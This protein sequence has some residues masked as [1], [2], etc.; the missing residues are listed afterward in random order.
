MNKN[1][2]SNKFKIFKML[3]LIIVSSML[4][5]NKTSFLLSQSSSVEITGLGP[6]IVDGKSVTIN[7]GA[8][9]MKGKARWN[10][11]DGKEDH[12]YFLATHTY[13]QY[14]NYTVTVTA[15]GYDGSS[16]TKSI[17]V[18]LSSYLEP[19]KITLLNPEINDYTVK[20][21]GIVTGAIKPL[22]FD[23]GDREVTESW[24]PGIHQYKKAGTYTIT[25]TAYGKDGT[26]S[27]AAMTVT[28]LN[29]VKANR[30]TIDG[31]VT[32]ALLGS[33]IEGVE[34]RGACHTT[35]TDSKGYYKLENLEA[36][37]HRFHF[38]KYEYCYERPR[39]TVKA[40][41]TIRYSKALKLE[42][43][44][45]LRGRVI[46]PTGEG[47]PG[48]KVIWPGGKVR[49]NIYDEISTTTDI[50]GNY[51][52]KVIP[53]GTRTFMF[54]LEGCEKK[55]QETTIAEGV[56]NV[57]ELTLPLFDFKRQIFGETQTISVGVTNINRNTGEVTMNGGDT[58]QPQI[59][60]TWDWDDGVIYDD[61]IFQNHTY[62]DITRNY[63]V[64]VTAHY[65]DGT[66][67]SVEISVRFVPPPINNIELPPEILVKIPDY[68]GYSEI[69]ANMPE[70]KELTY[71]DD[72]YFE[73][74]PR[75]T[76]EYVLSAAALIQKDFVN[77][78][79]NDN[80]FQVNG[81]FEQYLL[82]D[83]NLDN[84]IGMYSLWFTNPVAFVSKDS[85]LQETIFWSSFFHEMGHN[86]TLNFP[87]NYRYGGKI[88]GC[89]NA[90]FSESLAQIF[91]HATAYEMI[92]EFYRNNK[93]GL[94]E[95]LVD[96]IKQRAIITMN[97]VRKHYDKYI[98]EGKNFCSWNE[99]CGQPYDKDETK[100]TFMTI[101]FKFFE[102]AEKGGQG[103]KVPLKKMMEFLQV[104][105]EE[106]KN[107]Y[108]PTQNSLQ[109]DEF[110]A[111]FMVTALS[112]AFS[113]DLRPEFRDLN[114]PIS[115]EKYDDL[116]DLVS[117]ATSPGNMHDSN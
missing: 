24:F 48:I 68:E 31:Y 49:G 39:I 56:F 42:R 75:S 7:G 47:I 36:G 104:F 66:T 69:K 77:V 110:R 10:W 22:R 71:F 78:N 114:F 43:H 4:G 88:D 38:Y 98:D 52:L 112:Y 58:R 50:G 26:E 72:T 29:V 92:N 21:N 5:L 2:R 12:Q 18:S 87:A 16:D 64:K 33:V 67:D 44:G 20:Q 96:E 51:L 23:W 85:G 60:F 6:V 82:K 76:I 55:I 3:L 101:A 9:N 35:Y 109:G 84:N 115:N 100:D 90:I 53:T 94:T 19:P 15:Y 13:E 103:Y 46:K 74:T 37:N 27:S 117:A 62:S 113:T 79:D 63:T 73:I 41:K 65:P 45:H 97:V 70:N 91:Q 59:P 93:Y 17:E 14:G 1:K 107:E 116:M 57:L 105:N 32:D 99:Y 54:G 30:G 106:L 81:S 111:T 86:F 80:L 25:V 28:V 40:G 108:D 95:K 83:N 61:W 34:V 89:A 11:G 102:Y 8:K